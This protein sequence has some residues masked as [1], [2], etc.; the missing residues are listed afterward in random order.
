MHEPVTQ[1]LFRLGTAIRFIILHCRSIGERAGR[2]QE[3][4]R[5]ELLTNTHLFAVRH[6]AL[7][8]TVQHVQTLNLRVE[9]RDKRVQHLQRWGQSATAEV[10]R[11]QRTQQ[12]LLLAQ[13]LGDRIPINNGTGSSIALQSKSVGFSHPLFPAGFAHTDVAKEPLPIAL[14]AREDV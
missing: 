2:Q 13:T 10:H 1:T 12:G 11:L 8:R 6:L 9:E 5:H 14:V 4:P 3:T 7:E